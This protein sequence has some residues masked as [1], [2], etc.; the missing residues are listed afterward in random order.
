MRGCSAPARPPVCARVHAGWA[1]SKC[2][3]AAVHMDTPSRPP[4]RR[5]AARRTSPCSPKLC[6]A[7]ARRLAHGTN[8]RLRW[9]ESVHCFAKCPWNAALACSSATSP[10]LPLPQPAPMRASNCLPSPRAMAC[11]NFRR[12]G[13]AQCRVSARSSRRRSRTHKVRPA[14]AARSCTSHAARL[15]W[16]TQPS[17][18]L[19][20]A[21]W[22][23]NT[24]PRARAD[25]QAKKNAKLK[26]LDDTDSLL[27]F[28]R[29][30]VRTC[31]W[32]PAPSSAH[33]CQRTAESPATT[34]RLTRHTRVVAGLEAGTRGFG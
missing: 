19:T 15:P 1:C 31:A 26:W 11:K 27:E 18:P 5:K 25:E 9:S 20:S 22:L 12:H 28:V 33:S 13:A 10:L 2:K 34:I 21:S 4:A 32:R 8:I 16:P 3:D 17:A 7:F 6:V 14:P 23:I 30:E 29:P 24:C